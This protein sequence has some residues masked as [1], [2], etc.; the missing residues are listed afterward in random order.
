MKENELRI[1]SYYKIGQA[2]TKL[3][4]DSLVWYLEGGS[5]MFKPIP[6]TE[7]WLLKFG[8]ELNESGF[9]WIKDGV[10]IQGKLNVK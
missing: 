1:N 7:E 4:A 3:D 5:D 9:I 10:G 8:F 2:E 6:L